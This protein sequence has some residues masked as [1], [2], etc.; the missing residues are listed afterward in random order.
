MRIGI[1]AR[2][3][4]YRGGGIPEH[5]R[6]LVAGLR[7]L[8]PPEEIFVLAHRRGAAGDFPGP[9]RR[10][11]T[12]PHHRFEGWLLPAELATCGLGLLHATDMV[13]PF[14][15]RRPAVVTVHDLA[16]M[17]RP[18]LVTPESAR[19]YSGVKQS[20]R[21]AR[22][23]ITVSKHTADQVLVHTAADPA[24]IRVIPNAVAATFFE[25]PRPGED[26]AVLRRHDL[27]G[28]DYCLFVGTIEPRKNL[29][30]LLDAWLDVRHRAP[31][32]TLALAGSEGWLSGAVH[33]GAR[34]RRGSSWCGNPRAAV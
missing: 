30:T 4:A 12:P 34:W 2:L 14:A 23:I 20:V 31:A 8:D 18:D 28:R 32:L 22:L 21:R 3:C 29:T 19:Y 6:R 13:V 26:R 27:A 16:F 15:W 10:L 24:R 5:V 1:D 11:V 7:R 17:A 9:A 25:A 33:E